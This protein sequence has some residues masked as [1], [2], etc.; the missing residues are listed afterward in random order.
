MYDGDM[1]TATV[2]SAIETVL[3]SSE[4]T[5]S[6][7]HNTHNTVTI[8]LHLNIDLRFEHFTHSVQAVNFITTSSTTN[9]GN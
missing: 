1:P 8:F 3:S 9:Y 4:L 6:V 7:K 2:V 5:D